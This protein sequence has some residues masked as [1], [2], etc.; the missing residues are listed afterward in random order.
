MSYIFMAIFMAICLVGVF[1]IVYQ[2]YKITVIDAKARNL[3]HPK[4]MG[5]FA[6]SGRSSEG[7][8]IYL[9]NRKKYPIKN[10]SKLEQEE[11]KNRKKKILVG[12]IFLVVGAIG[13]VYAFVTII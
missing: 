2:I 13:T 3:K 7:L 12:I 10:M 4:L 1:L 5:L 11:I 8:I 6:I 9:L